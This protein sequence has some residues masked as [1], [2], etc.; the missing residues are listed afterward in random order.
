MSYPSDRL[1]GLS[2]YHVSPVAADA[3]TYKM[4]WS[5]SASCTHYISHHMQ[6][7]I[8]MGALCYSIY[9]FSLLSSLC[10]MHG[11]F[12]MLCLIISNSFV[13]FILLHADY[14][15]HYISTLCANIMICLFVLSLM[16]CNIVTFLWNFISHTIII[17]PTY[18]VLCEQPFIFFVLAF[19]QFIPQSTFPFLG[20][21]FTP[22]VQP[23]VLQ[24]YDNSIMP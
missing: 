24:W 20:W 21:F 7:T 22:S 1:C 9:I 3:L 2:Y 13:G 15:V 18:E 10:M 11:H 5:G 8:F 23:V 12:C 14:C 16:S 17:K 4:L 19:C 6:D